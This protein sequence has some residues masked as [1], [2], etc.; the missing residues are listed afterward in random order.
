MT[1]K[2]QHHRSPGSALFTGIADGW[3]LARQR[4]TRIPRYWKRAILVIT[5]TIILSVIV[6]VALS[7]RYH[8][9][10]WPANWE[11]ALLVAAAPLLVVSALGWTGVYRHVTRYFDHRANARLV[12]STT[13]AA[14]LWAVIVF[15]SGQQGI[16]RST[17]LLFGVTAPVGL[18][19]CR[20]LIGWVLLLPASRYAPPVRTDVRTTIIYGAGSAGLQLL[21]ALRES[22]ER[23]LV[24]FVDD[25]PSL[26]GQYVGGTKVYRP[27]RLYGLI[28]TPGVSQVLVAS[29]RTHR[30]QARDLMR[31]LKQRAIDV[32]VMPDL[33]DIASGR[34][35]LADLRPL[36]IEDLLG[37]EPV[38]P[39]PEL[40]SSSVEGKVVLIT[41]AGGSVGSE[42]TR[43]IARLRPRQIVVVDASET[44]LH[45]ITSILADKLS[46]LYEPGLRPKLTPIL[47]SVLNSALMHE[48][49]SKHD[50]QT[51]YHAAAYKH[52]PI[53]EENPIVGLN[54]NAI[55]TLTLLRC[56]IAGNVERFVL[57]STDKAVHPSSIMGASKRLA[58]LFVQA[59]AATQPGTVLTSVRFGN[60]LDSSGSVIQRFRQQLAEG[61]PLTVT[62]PDATRYFMSVREAAELVI[63]AGAMATG[64]EVFLLEMGDPVRIQDVARIM[65]NMA[66]LEIKDAEHPDGDI[67]IAYIGLRPGEKLTEELLINPEAK[68]TR[69]PRIKCAQEPHLNLEQMERA[70]SL[71]HYAMWRSDM[72]AINKILRWLL[73]GDPIGAAS[74][75]S[76]S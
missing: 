62:H 5:D 36:K 41:G 43:Q 66:G 69:H 12:A 24:G 75:G 31:A 6:W 2:L 47:G 60:V 48:V 1:A 10:Y 32:K 29:P 7:V 61:G 53:V 51:I 34:V 33:K 73:D 71:L 65:I 15:M 39:D 17:I 59:Y 45:D 20:Q 3:A 38:A 23:Q 40:L 11:A 26:W 68:A 50:V 13:L 35:R 72:A 70:A 22:G 54:N 44:A 4:L 76:A 25:D 52:V 74:G 42:I 27:E 21:R 30:G 67:E 28:A 8:D 46:K 18:I 57:I 55:G 64:G 19:S 16:P 37:R 49:I 9:Y 58:E 14:I 63:Q 56:A